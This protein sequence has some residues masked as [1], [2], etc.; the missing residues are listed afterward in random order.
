MIYLD[1]AATTYP[2]PDAVVNAVC[3]SMSEY[4]ANPGRGGYPMAIE[5]GDALF[6][7]RER[8][9]R[10]FGME[11]RPIP[12]ERVIFTPGCTWSI[13]T[14]LKGVL[15][16]G[17]HVVISDLEHNAVVRPLTALE[18]IGVSVTRAH[19][20]EGDPDKTVQSFRSSMTARTRLVFC[21]HASNVFGT[22]LPI[23]QI[24][25]LCRSR[26]VLFGTD[27][28]QTAG[29]LDIEMERFGINMLCAPAHKGLYGIMG[30][31][32][33][34]LSDRCEPT[35]L[36]E[37]GTGSSSA[38]RQQ[39]RELPDYYE[40]GTPP[41]AAICA[42]S[43]GIDCINR[44][45]RRRIREHEYMLISMLYDRFCKMDN[46]TLYTRRPQE[47]TH[48]P[49]LSFNVGDMDAE[50]AAERLAQNGIAVR[51]GYH[52]AYDAHLAYGTANR[53]TVRV[54][55]SMYTTTGDIERL[56]AAVGHM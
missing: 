2:K 7:C 25:A 54:C 19:V 55:P 47:N 53:G 42:L 39:P 38:K 30:C 21:T 27:C 36:I 35:P 9:G 26:G 29:T 23:E 44:V 20:Y 14:C 49:L 43:A 22:L 56:I 1:N 6:R 37:G 52:C 3:R 31:G 24:A 50:A 8:V 32:I 18:H 45:G 17:D 5:S 51:A 40:S 48:A 34:L 4:G 15:R 28:A 46:V 13:N 41:V 33:L 12:P 11:D 16:R 10:F